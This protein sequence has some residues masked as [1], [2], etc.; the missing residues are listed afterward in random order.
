[1]ARYAVRT[2]V[3]IL[4]LLAGWIALLP[5][6]IGQERNVVYGSYPGGAIA[7]VKTAA[8]EVVSVRPNKSGDI[9]E[10]VKF[11]P[12]GF[13]ATNAVLLE[14]IVYAYGLHDPGLSGEVKG[15]AGAP[16]WI[17]FP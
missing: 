1:M 15:I 16:S 13:T 12:D 11:P 5:I 9:A 14:I 3:R 4:L 17:Q 7:G 2:R 8:F 10:R 6:A